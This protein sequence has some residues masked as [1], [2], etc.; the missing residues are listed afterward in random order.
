MKYSNIYFFVLW[1]HFIMEST[2][3]FP[4]INSGNNGKSDPTDPGTN[5][6]I[7]LQTGPVCKK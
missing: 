5:A 4:D 3:G 1:F 2:F 7:I 6:I